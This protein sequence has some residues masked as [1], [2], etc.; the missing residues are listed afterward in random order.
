MTHTDTDTVVND[1]GTATATS[2]TSH[3]LEA[4][5]DTERLAIVGFELDEGSL[6]LVDLDLGT[7][8]EVDVAGGAVPGD[9]RW[10]MMRYGWMMMEG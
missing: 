9:L 8:A 7:E 2:L 10:E 5:R 3:K 4:V 6:A 1:T